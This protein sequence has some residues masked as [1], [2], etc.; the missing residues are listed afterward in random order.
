MKNQLSTDRL[1][2]VFAIFCPIRSKNDDVSVNA[3]FVVV[4]VSFEIIS[5]FQHQI[6]ANLSKKDMEIYFFRFVI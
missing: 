1:V 2:F 3:G 4:L 5:R 6:H